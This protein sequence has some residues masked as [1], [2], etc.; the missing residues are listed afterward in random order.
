MLD[1]EI[2]SVI[3]SVDVYELAEKTRRNIALDDNEKTVAAQLDEWAR[4]IGNTGL[5][6]DHEIAEFV[7]KTLNE[8]VYNAPHELLDAMFERGSVGEFDDYE[9]TVSPKNTLVSYEAAKGGNVDKSY[10]DISVLKPKWKNRQIETEIT[11]ADLRRNGWKSVA[12]LTT[13]ANDALHNAMFRDIF[14]EID[15]AIANGAENYIAN[16]GAMP[17]AAAMD[18]MALYLNDRNAG[19]SSIVALSKYVQAV[20]KMQGYLSDAMLNE[21]HSTGGLGKYDGV[22]LHG[23][24]GAKK[25]ANGDLLIP[26]KRIFGIAGKIGT[27]DMKGEVHIYEDMDNDNER[28]ELKI[29]DFTYGWSFNK[30]TLDNV[31]KIVLE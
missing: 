29:K 18:A 19:G 27:L 9:T 30:D 7:R 14:T 10:L 5:D 12:L 23:I 28:V 22:E 8:E 24:S 21:I 31:C 16:G 20:S 3:K 1:H 13:Y 6:K 15:A 11:Y 17:T 25:Y 2:A 4:E 26:D